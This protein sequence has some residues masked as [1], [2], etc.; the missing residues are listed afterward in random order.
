MFIRAPLLAEFD[1]QV[2]TA[3]ATVKTE[4]S[5]KEAC[6][7]VDKES[8]V[9]AARQRDILVTSFHPELTEDPYWHTYVEGM[10]REIYEQKV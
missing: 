2:V 8:A 9:V 6:E 1:S 3:L 4:K 10:V 7:R 5:S